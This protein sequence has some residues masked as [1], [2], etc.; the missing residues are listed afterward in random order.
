M[1]TF[2]WPLMLWLLLAIPLLI[3]LY[4]L[5]LRRKKRAAV[6]Y[7]NL[8]LVNAALGVGNRLRRHVPPVLFLIA[9]ALMLLATARPIALV[10]LPTQQE[11][12]IL[13]M[14]VSGS[15]RATD[16]Q[17]NRLQAA[18]AAA[19]AF[20]ADLPSRTKVGIVAFAATASV[21]QAPT[22]SREDLVA[23]IDRFQLQRGT[24]IGSGLIVA[25]A[26]LFPDAGI[27]I[28][29]LIYGQSKQD[30]S[31][32]GPIGKSGKPKEEFKPVPP[33]SNGSAAVILLTD[34]QRTTGPDALEAA[35]LV[36]DRGVRIFTVGVG[37]KEGETIGFEG[38]SMRVRLDEESLKRIAEM[39]H[40]EYFYA[41][42]AVD[43]KKIYESLNARI[44][45]E[46]KQ[47][48]I[49]ALF[50]ALA[51]LFATV[52]AVLSLWWHGRVL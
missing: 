25:L 40:G 16:V 32:G 46:K 12:I 47:T 8:D 43:L 23:A 51:A 5:I 36:A 24:A 41:G 42:T 50:A 13:A 1:M 4:V 26:T 30:E 28:G 6:R 15:M 27:D 29:Q 14:D 49:S 34:G 44:A 38:W 18:Q 35:K 17:P 39:T 52:A 37:T 45:L 31:N 11:T 20:V 33:G 21:V 3:G 22:L 2:Q 10:T 7:A 9:L 48:E 19:K